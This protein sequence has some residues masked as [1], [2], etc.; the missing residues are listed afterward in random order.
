[1]INTILTFHRLE[2]VAVRRWPSTGHQ[3]V[4]AV[5]LVLVQGRQGR[6]VRHLEVFSRQYTCHVRPYCLHNIYGARLRYLCHR[7][8][9]GRYLL[10]PSALL[11]PGKS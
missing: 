8:Y 9:R 2:T 11:H 1:M 3:R 6:V 7:A 5:L 4:D 10:H